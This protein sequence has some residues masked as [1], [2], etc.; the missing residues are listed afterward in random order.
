MFVLQ[1][2]HHRFISSVYLT[3]VLKTGKG[4]F[5]VFLYTFP[6]AFVSKDVNWTGWHFHAKRRNVYFKNTQV[7][8]TISLVD[9]TLPERLCLEDECEFEKDAVKVIGLYNF[10][11]MIQIFAWTPVLP[12]KHAVATCKKRKFAVSCGLQ[13]GIFTGFA[14]YDF[15][16]CMLCCRQRACRK[17]RSGN[18][19]LCYCILR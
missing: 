13:E 11:S 8:A 18:Y 12:F 15:I 19:T 7:P 16:C 3:A 6:E 17:T 14:A 9:S 2:Q 4:F 10:T 5:Q 1:Q